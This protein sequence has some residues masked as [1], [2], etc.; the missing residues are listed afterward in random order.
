MRCL[1]VFKYVLF[2]SSFN[3]LF[4]LFFI[5]EKNESGFSIYF[6]YC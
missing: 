6:D 3:Q 2:V 5:G 4:L 1:T